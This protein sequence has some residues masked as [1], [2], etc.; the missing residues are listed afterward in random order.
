MISIRKKKTNN[1]ILLVLC[2]V[3]KLTMRIHD[4]DD[5]LLHKI[6]LGHLI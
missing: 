4:S 1:K 5:Y 3:V 6:D 2:N